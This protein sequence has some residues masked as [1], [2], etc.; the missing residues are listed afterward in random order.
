MSCPTC[1][2]TMNFLTRAEDMNFYHCPR[3]G[4]AVVKI[5]PSSARNYP[6]RVYVP[7]LV[8]RCRRFET[9]HD[10]NSVAQ[11]WHRLGIAEAI[12]T[13]ENRPTPDLGG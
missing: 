13:P 9:T 8:D 11:K 7:K 3:C 1:D 6:D 2:H 10:S 12:N 4:T 5:D